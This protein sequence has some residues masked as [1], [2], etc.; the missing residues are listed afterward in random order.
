M[1]YI[2]MRGRTLLGTLVK[3]PRYMDLLMKPHGYDELFTMNNKW[4]GCITFT[5]KTGK[6]NDGYDKYI[7]SL[8][9]IHDGNT[10]YREKMEY[11][12]YPAAFHP[13]MIHST[14][15]KNKV[16][17]FSTEIPYEIYHLLERKHPVDIIYSSHPL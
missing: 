1:L 11:F 14:W 10:F 13:I 5:K 4:N 2:R 7:S 16:K 8:I 6:V 17:I 3:E 12:L 15:K 9:T